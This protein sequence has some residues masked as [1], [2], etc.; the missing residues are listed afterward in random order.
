M[1]RLIAVNDLKK[2][3]PTSRSFAEMARG[4]HPAVRALD[5]VSFEVDEHESLGLLG[6]SGCGKTTTGRLLLKLE[7]PTSGAIAIDNAPISRLKGAALKE[8]RRQAQLVF[9][10]P[11]DALNPRMTMEQ[12][13]TE[14]LLNFDIPK[15][16]HADRIAAALSQARLPRVKEVLPKYPH[17]L[18]GGQ[19]QRVV[20]AR[21]LMLGPRFIVADEPVSMLDVSVRAGILNLMRDVQQAAGLSAI[22]ISHDLALVRYVAKRTLVMY[23]GRIVEDGPTEEIVLRP[24]HPYTKA[25]IA[26]VP[27]PRVDQDRGALPIK[28]NVPDAKRPP[29]GCRFHDRCPIAIARCTT[30]D[31]LLLQAAAGHRVACHLVNK[32]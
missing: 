9:Q 23:L 22:Y 6:E 5:G 19:L 4:E 30:D 16:E 14:P 25:L 20:L 17:Q 26:A 32:Q 13:L 31:P 3:Y 12:S 24:Q 11:F 27:V 21:A 18:S 2:H 1:G 29:S 8:F 7:E 15:A 10:N 28:G